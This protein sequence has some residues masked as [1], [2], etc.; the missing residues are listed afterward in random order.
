MRNPGAAEQA[1]VLGVDGA[2]VAD[3]QGDEDAGRVR[4]AEHREEARA[5][6]FA[7]PLDP[8]GQRVALAELHLPAARPHIAAGAYAPLKE[9]AFVIEPVR[10]HAAVR[11]LEPDGEAPTLARVDRICVRQRGG[12]VIEARCEAAAIP[13][14]Q[15][16]LWHAGAC[17]VG[18]LDVELEAHAALP[19]GRQAR[20]HAGDDE[21]PPFELGGEPLCEPALRAPS[22]PRKAE[23]EGHGHGHNGPQRPEP[24]EGR[25]RQ[26]R[27]P[28]RRERGR[29]G[30]LLLQPPNSHC[31]S[32]YRC[33][34]AGAA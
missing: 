2:L 23:R 28:P 31:K 21:V 7:H 1:P 14:E 30:R 6:G 11:A 19:E 13:R 29:Q 9:P 25:A 3:H 32:D 24:R 18:A 10:I 27:P 5:H 20:H 34:H 12:G 33:V 8:V 17:A 26:H 22:G 15:D 16:P 4:I